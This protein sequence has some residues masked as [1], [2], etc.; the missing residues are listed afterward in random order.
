M[1]KI[2]LIVSFSICC[3]GYVFSQNDTTTTEKGTPVEPTTSSECTD[4]VYVVKIKGSSAIG[5]Y[6]EATGQYSF[7]SGLSSKAQGDYS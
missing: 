1:R 2:L 5:Q 3:L 6:T 4:C 7:A